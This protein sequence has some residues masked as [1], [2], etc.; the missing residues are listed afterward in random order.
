M[1]DHV[2]LHARDDFARGPHVDQ[3]LLRVEHAAER[4][5]V[6]CVDDGA[7][8]SAKLPRQLSITVCW[9]APVD[10]LDFYALIGQIVGEQRS[11]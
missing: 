1:Q 6:R 9:R 4:Y 8:Q 7:P 2:A 3:H 11:A 5:L 10:A